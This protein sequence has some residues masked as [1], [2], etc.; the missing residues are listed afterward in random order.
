MIRRYPL[1][2]TLGVLLLVAG[3][4]GAWAATAR[5]WPLAL[6]R[7]PSRPLPGL[8]ID[9]EAIAA[10]TTV[11][12]LAARR[13]AALTGRRVR[14]VVREADGVRP[15]LE[16]TLGELGVAVDV[17][18]VDVTRAAPRARGRPAHARRPRRP[19]A[20][21]R[22]RRPAGAEPRSTRGGR[23]PRAHE[24]GARRRARCRLA[25]I[26]S[27][28]TSSPSTTG[29]RSTPT[30]PPTSWR[31]PLSTRASSRSSCPSPTSPPAVTRASLSRIDISQVV[32][33]FQTYFSRWG[34]QGPRARNI[35]VAASHIDGLV[36]EA[37]ES[38]SFNDVVGPRTEDN[39]FKTAFE[40]VKGEYKEGTGGGTCQV[41]STLHAIAFFAGPRHHPAPAAL[42]PERV[43]PR[44]GSTRRS[45]TRSSTSSCATPSPSRWSCT[46]RSRANVLKMEL[47]GADKPVEVTFGKSVLSTTPYERKVEEDPDGLQAQ[48]QAEGHRRHGAV[49]LAGADVPGRD[50]QGG[51]LARRVPAD[52][53]E[54]WLVPPGF[55]AS[56]LPPLGEDLPKA[57]DGEAAGAGAGWGRPG[58]SLATAPRTEFDH[59][60]ACMRAFG[61]CPRSGSRPAAAR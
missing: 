43:H 17:D 56:T 52:A 13:A 5:W 36:I 8:R 12:V 10:G 7:D 21:R 49:A 55:D 23:P 15:V 59:M 53:S 35:E 40:I 37:G 14:L 34:D 60:P 11:D 9:G 28:T 44:R 50:A 1:R 27:T 45:C 19:G 33:S 31:V 16:T 26:W 3:A 48:A 57:D 18:A 46:R 47:L 30:R 4:C 25:S 22:A 41:A 39:G 20:A 61:R 32:A 2:L 42:A 51:E 29:A 58:L 6:A 54:V 24:G 38:I